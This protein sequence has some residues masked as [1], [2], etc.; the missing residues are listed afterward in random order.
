MRDEDQR[1]GS[2]LRRVNGGARVGKDHPPRTLPLRCES[3]AGGAVWGIFTA[4]FASGAPVDPAREA[5]ASRGPAPPERFR[6]NPASRGSSPSSRGKRSSFLEPIA[7]FVLSDANSAISI[8][9]L[10]R[11]LSPCEPGIASIRT[12]TGSARGP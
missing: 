9:E 8:S 11:L 10:R 4:A 5:A 12:P 3:G 1:S 2:L 6:R 7:G